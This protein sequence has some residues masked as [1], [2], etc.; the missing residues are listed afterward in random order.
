MSSEQKNVYIMI[1]KLYYNSN[2]LYCIRYNISY[3]E[4]KKIEKYI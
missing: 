1:L 3:P 2:H 4:K